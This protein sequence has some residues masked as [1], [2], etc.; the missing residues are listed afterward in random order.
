MILVFGG[1][2]EGKKVAALLEQAGYPYYY[3]TKTPV[4]MPSMTYGYCRH[5]ALTPT[6]L[7][8]FCKTENIKAIIHAS[9]PFA[10]ELHDTIA[11][12][13]DIPVYRFERE[14]PQRTM[15]PLVHYFDDYTQALD[16]LGKHPVSRLLALTGV[17]TIERLRDYWEAH[18]TLFRIL[19]RESSLRQA[20]D[21]GFP[22]KDLIL[23]MPGNEEEIINHHHI[24]GILTKE[25]GESGL[26]SVKIATA[27]KTGIPIFIIARPVLPAGFIPVDEHNL[28]SHL[29]G[30]RV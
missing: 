12:V 18:P 30:I 11:T 7:Q 24:T 19:P 14:F 15:H 23:E 5:G 25:S 22:E 4:L 21:A 13:K 27:I 26:L 9:H 17:Q 3:S 16:H 29:N 20:L 2:T 28:L 10:T 1:T 8:S 6:T